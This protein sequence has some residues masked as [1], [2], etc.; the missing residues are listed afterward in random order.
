MRFFCA[1]QNVSRARIIYM[2]THTRARARLQFI[3]YI[4][5]TYEHVVKIFIDINIA[6]LSESS[7]YRSQVI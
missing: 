3:N 2:Y 1:L 4:A 7:F 5:L 6:C